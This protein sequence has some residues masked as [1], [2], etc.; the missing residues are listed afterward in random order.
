MQAV[1][2]PAPESIR[3]ERVPDPT[4]AADEVIVQVARCGICGTDVHIYRN[5][6]MSNFPVIPGHEFGGVIVETGKEV[7]DFQVGDRVAVDPNLYCGHCDMCRNEMANHCL[8]WQGVGITRPG[9]FAEYVAAPARACYH[10]PDAMTD[11]QA[12]FIEPLACVVHAMKR[13]R[14]LPA[15][16]V[17][18]LGAGPMGLLLVQALRRMGASY[19]AVVEKQ[20]ARL[21]LAKAMGASVA[22]PAG[23]EQDA[24]LKEV[25][26]RGFG[27]VIDATGVPAVIE[28]AFRYLRPRGTFLQFG[29]AP[30]QA[31]VSVSPYDIFHN[32]W[33]IVGSFALCYT[34]LPA[35]D[36]LASGAIDVGPLV[37]H[38]AP[39]HDFAD[40]F[41]KFAAGQT[42]KVHVH[43][44]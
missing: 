35:I 41:A 20:P 10:L 7:A 43:M 16:P 13:I 23:A 44:G 24:A 25:A 39:L 27:V 9:G 34:F 2:F 36:W 22:V 42:L 15:D 21:E 37:S 6:Y 38:V 11:A 26:P 1:L 28:G 19:V 31:R 32:D 3:I 40:V 12:A 29:V 4:C 33:T 5:E 14:V 18:I 17:L 8:H 30:N